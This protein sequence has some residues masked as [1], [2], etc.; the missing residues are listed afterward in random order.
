MH[1]IKYLLSTSTY[2]ASDCL[3]PRFLQTAVPAQ[4]YQSWIPSHT[5]VSAS[6]SAGTG[7]SA[8]Y[9]LK[10]Y[11]KDFRRSLCSPYLSSLDCNNSRGPDTE[12]EHLSLVNKLRRAS[13]CLLLVGASDTRRSALA[14]PLPARRIRLFCRRLMVESRFHW[15]ICRMVAYY[16][17]NRDLVSTLPQS[18]A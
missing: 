3:H 14:N 2:M 9:R 7:I 1:S 18:Q 10:I 16:A 12:A 13:E 15:G 8:F 6:I 17:E 11:G 4:M 5:I